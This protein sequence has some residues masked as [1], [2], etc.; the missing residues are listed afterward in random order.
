MAIEDLGKPVVLLA[1]NGFVNDAHSAASS[2]GIPGIRVIGTPIACESTDEIDIEKGIE[3]AL[4]KIIEALTKPLTQ[5]EASPQPKTE[6]EPRIAFR[7][8]VQDVNNFFYRKGW[9]DGLP[10]LP[11]TEAAVA[12]ML[13]GTDLPADHVVTKL[14]PRGGYATV[15]KI[16][17][18]AVMGGALPVHMPVII[19]AVE[20]LSDGKTRFD[21]FE[22]STGSWAPFFLINGPVRTDIHINSSSG[23]LSPGN[24][25]NAAIGRSVGLIV[26]NIGGAR[27]GIEDMGVLGNPG[28]WSLVLGENEEESPWEPY[29]VS[30]GYQKEDNVLTVFFPNQYRMSIPGQT[31][32]EGIATSWANMRP[33]ALSALVVIPDQAKIL[34]S[35][36][37]SKQRVRDFIIEQN[38]PAPKP[39]AAPKPG[40]VLP[41][42]PGRFGRGLQNEDFLLVVAG[43]PGSFFGLLSSAGGFNNSFVSKK[44]TLPKDWD[45]LAAKY[46]N[47]VPNY[48]IY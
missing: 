2:K 19:A 11:P 31:H 38:R 43:G 27:K 44:I 41:T 9:S 10:V 47:M 5:A 23:A 48:E 34:A 7:G 14:I 20:A 35:A 4:D 45:K 3:G 25:A 39:G 26:K 16:A 21:T 8:S 36:G 22:V 12:E 40:G 15:E 13:T 18:N 37:W 29:H 17:V 46:R 33:G 30:S 6:P 1:N 24:I 32:A 42:D 28:K